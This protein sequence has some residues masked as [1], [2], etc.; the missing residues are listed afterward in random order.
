MSLESIFMM[1]A[2][3]SFDQRFHFKL[4]MFYNLWKFLERFQAEEL[5][6]LIR[7]RLHWIFELNRL[8]LDMNLFDLQF[9]HDEAF[10]HFCQI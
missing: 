1:E 6:S 8:K 4:W 3:T 10:W 5:D 7:L 9:L 2:F